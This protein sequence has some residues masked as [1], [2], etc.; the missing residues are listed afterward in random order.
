MYWEQEVIEKKWN[1]EM[2]LLSSKALLSIVNLY[3]YILFI[4]KIQ[5]K[6]GRRKVWQKEKKKFCVNSCNQPCSHKHSHSL[7]VLINCFILVFFLYV[8]A[9]L[10]SLLSKT[11]MHVF[12][13]FWYYLY[14]FTKS[15]EKTQ[16]N[17]SYMN[18]WMEYKECWVNISYLCDT[19]ERLWFWT[20]FPLRYERIN[21]Q[22][23]NQ[24]QVCWTNT[25]YT[26]FYVYI[27]Y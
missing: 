18:G 13:C 20:N 23:Q 6:V 12:I 16:G 26:A 17:A 2:K 19:R 27:I 21:L 5:I 7:W 14:N 8:H 10:F 15:R 22:Y 3:T 9:S 25:S 11:Y 1:E 4:Y 24:R